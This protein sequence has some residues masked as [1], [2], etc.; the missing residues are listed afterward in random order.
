MAF[1]LPTQ[2]DYPSVFFYIIP[3]MSSDHPIPIP[4]I[5]RGQEIAAQDLLYQ[6]RDKRIEFSYPDPRPLLDRI[7][8]SDPAQLQRDF[9]SM[10]VGE[11]IDF[12]AEA[13]KAM[14]LNHA[15]MEQACRFSIPFSALPESIVRGSYDL[16]PVVF[17]KLALRTMVENEIGSKYLDG[18][19]EMPYA[20]KIARRRAYGARTLHFISGNVPVVAAL[21]IAR[22]ALIK[23]D[24][25]IKVTPNDPL[26][27]SAIVGAMMDVDSNHPVTKHFSVVYWSKELQDFE[28][29]LIQPRYL[30]KIIS[31]GGA[32]GGVNSTLNHGNLQASGID[33]IALG[34]KFSISILGSETFK[35]SEEI[36]RVAKLTAKDAGSFN[37][38]SC[39]SSRFHF[40]QA[41]P[42]QAME[43]ARRLY[44]HMQLQDPG[45]STIPKEFPSDLQHELQAARAQ[46][47]FY[48]VV[49]GDKQEG[50]VV[51]SL[52]GELPDFFPM[53]K[54]VVVIPFDD[55]LQ[56]VD[57]I[58]PSTQT[59]GIYPESLKQPL[60]DL[61]VARGVCRFISIGH[62]VDYSI[63]G[64]FNSTEIMRR[65]GRWILDESYPSKW[66]LPGFYLRK[67][68]LILKHHIL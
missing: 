8:L 59:V 19:V 23:S 54:V 42:G 5:L 24:N 27:A 44:D 45:L 41:S 49:G 7:V 67:A 35:S 62:T 40:V 43:Y 17:S 25:I 38:E 11:I 34:P 53:H 14:T 50:A 61:L 13:G 16:I 47:D 28:H 33:V 58:H 4:F 10:H 56:L 60:R 30:E 31:W 66:E 36:N 26:T 39:G 6:S 57:R 64:P 3:R 32:L 22:A 20:D 52:T 65:A 48:Y 37:M 9:A 55:P 51:V 21:S 63:G 18:W 1:F 68:W 15:R 12:L 46:D 29:E 2:T